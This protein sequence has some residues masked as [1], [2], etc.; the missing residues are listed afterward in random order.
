MTSV[1]PLFLFLFWMVFF[2]LILFLGRGRTSISRRMWWGEERGQHCLLRDGFDTFTTALYSYVCASILHNGFCIERT[3]DG[4]RDFR[5]LRL[6]F[7]T[8]PTKKKKIAG[9]AM[10]APSSRGRTLC[11]AALFRN[12]THA[13]NFTQRQFSISPF[14]LVLREGFL[15]WL[16][17]RAY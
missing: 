6:S 15:F 4:P 10:D 8:L 14:L 3:N 5:F 1:R 13:L 2:A 17:G 16:V 7:P 12:C 9:S 11:F